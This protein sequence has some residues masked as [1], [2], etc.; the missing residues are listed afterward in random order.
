M[1]QLLMRMP[2]SNSF[3]C[4]CT[5]DWLQIVLDPAEELLDM[6]SLGTLLCWSICSKFQH[7]I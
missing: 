6:L 4:F 2:A 7:T 3:M 5:K 1:S